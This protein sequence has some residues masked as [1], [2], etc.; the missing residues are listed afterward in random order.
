MCEQANED[1]ANFVLETDCCTERRYVVFV[2]AKR[3]NYDNA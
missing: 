1:K 3:I 2:I